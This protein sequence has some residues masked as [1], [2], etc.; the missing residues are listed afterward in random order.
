[1]KTLAASCQDAARALR[2]LSDHKLAKI[3]L[4]AI[5]PPG[6][7][8]AIVLPALEELE[9]IT[10]DLRRAVDEAIHGKPRLTVAPRTVAKDA[11]A[12]AG[13]KRSETE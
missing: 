9:R 5:L 6:R 12:T 1:M 4:P 8:A 2:T 7:Q 11:G 10:T 13:E 3:N